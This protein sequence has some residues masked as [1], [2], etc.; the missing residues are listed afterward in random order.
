MPSKRL[1]GFIVI[2]R[3]TKA[4]ITE[5]PYDR[6]GHVRVCGGRGWATTAP[7]RNRPLTRRA[8]CCR[9]S[10]SASTAG[11]LDRYGL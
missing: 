10:P 6:M 3:G 11:E 5:E 2:R 7:T 1:A 9:K 8:F 4:L